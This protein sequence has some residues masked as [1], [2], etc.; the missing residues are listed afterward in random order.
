MLEVDRIIG[1]AG[2]T[3]SVH[4][5]HM[6]SVHTG[7]TESVRTTMATIFKKASYFIFSDNIIPPSLKSVPPSMLV[8]HA[9]WECI[10]DRCMLVEDAYI[11]CMMLGGAVRK[12]AE[13]V[14]VY[15]LGNKQMPSYLSANTHSL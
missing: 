9:G 7:H 11:S 4:T 5:G 12:L 14:S 15:W 13:G 8:E 3:E 2:H 10:N 6:E 1:F